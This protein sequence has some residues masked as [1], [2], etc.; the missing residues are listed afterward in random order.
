MKTKSIIL[1]D[2]IPHDISSTIDIDWPKVHKQVEPNLLERL[3]LLESKA[4]CQLVLEKKKNK[5]R[6]VAEFF[7]DK[8]HAI[9]SKS[10]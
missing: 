6:L 5:F 7:N 1:T 3:R 4:E 10:I 2:W 8:T 9:F